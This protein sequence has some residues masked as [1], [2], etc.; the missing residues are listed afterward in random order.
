MLV[1]GGT[2]VGP[3]EF[4]GQYKGF[5]NHGTGTREER[6]AFAQQQERLA[7][8]SAPVLLGHEHKKKHHALHYSASDY[9][10]DVPL[11]RAESAPTHDMQLCYLH[12]FCFLFFFLSLYFRNTHLFFV[13][14]FSF[15]CVCLCLFV[16]Y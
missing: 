11:T 8:H 1:T 12:I 7:R 15:V 13:P 3:Q 16:V 10:Y 9:L 5:I 14:F 2:G 6:L 4:A